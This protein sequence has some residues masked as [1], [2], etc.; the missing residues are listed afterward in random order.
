MIV[1]R[2]DDPQLLPSGCLVQ[3]LPTPRPTPSELPYTW[4]WMGHEQQS[5]PRKLS[6]VE[7]T[8]A[9][10]DEAAPG[11]FFWHSNG[12]PWEGQLMM[13]GWMGIDPESVASANP[14]S[15][16]GWACATWVDFN[17]TCN[18]CTYP[19]PFFLNFH[20]MKLNSHLFSNWFIA[21]LLVTLFKHLSLFFFVFYMGFLFCVLCFI[22]WFC[23]FQ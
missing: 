13:D 19:P 21:L 1:V 15:Q 23:S 14:S 4:P 17:L 6:L 20:F 9:E 11:R 22:L 2:N 12:T 16:Y 18:Y 3:E 7:P 10:H 5:L 8:R